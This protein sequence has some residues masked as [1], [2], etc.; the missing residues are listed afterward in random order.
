[1]K[2]TGG[3]GQF[4]ELYSRNVGLALCAMAGNPVAVALLPSEGREP[5][6]DGSLGGGLLSECALPQA[7]AETKS[8]CGR[9]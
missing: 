5:G 8:I 4:A 6:K 9:L 1:M 7:A 2:D 3:R